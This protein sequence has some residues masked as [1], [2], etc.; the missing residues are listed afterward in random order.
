M[1]LFNRLRFYH[2][3]LGGLA[4]LSYISE[5]WT[6]LHV[7]IGYVLATILV[8]RI[9][10]LVVAPRLLPRPAWLISAQ[11]NQPKLGTGN[12]ILG[13]TFIAGIMLALA[14]TIT[15]GLMLDQSRAP[16]NAQADAATSA[17]TGTSISAS[18]ISPAHADE[19]RK[20]DRREKSKGSKVLKEIHETAANG[21]FLLVGLHV[22]YLLLINR[23]Y[24]LRMIFIGDKR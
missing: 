5:D 8:L 16:Q 19:G 11:D 20:S 22:A 12:P 9:L 13:K 18:I 24:A 21:I 6:G 2:A 10:S 3:A 4:A 17:G 1:S 23:R 14:L 15:T 7:L